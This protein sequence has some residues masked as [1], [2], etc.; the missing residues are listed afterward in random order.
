MIH[1]KNYYKEN[2]YFV[3]RNFLNNDLSLLLYNYCL[4]KSSSIDFKYFNFKEKYDK[5]WDGNFED[6]QTPGAYS[7]YGDPLMDTL[8][9]LSQNKIEETIDKKVFS[10][11]SYWRLYQRGH[12]LESHIDRPSCEISTTLCLGYNTENVKNYNWPI[13]LETEKKEILQINLN[14]GDMLI[15]NGVKLRHWREEFLGLNHAQVFL[16]YNDTQGDFKIEYDNRPQLGIPLKYQR[17]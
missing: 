6:P 16:H 1:N 12:K 17:S 13:F 14:P 5:R 2:N 4:V 15:Y 10:N 9:V 7:Y 8:L 3:Y 11:Y